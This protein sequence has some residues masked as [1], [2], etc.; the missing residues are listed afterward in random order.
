[1]SDRST[2]MSL[3]GNLSKLFYEYNKL[4]E[5]HMLDSVPFFGYYYS[6]HRKKPHREEAQKALAGIVFDITRLTR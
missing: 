5:Y 3:V 1:M 6:E 2:S 4:Q